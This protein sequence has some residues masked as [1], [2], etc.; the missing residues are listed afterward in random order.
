MPSARVRGGCWTLTCRRVQVWCNGEKKLMLRDRTFSRRKAMVDETGKHGACAGHGSTPP[1]TSGSVQQSL[2]ATFLKRGLSR[3]GALMNGAQTLKEYI[4]SQPVQQPPSAFYRGRRS[5]GEHV[6]DPFEVWSAGESFLRLQR[7]EHDAEARRA[8]ARSR[9]LS[10]IA[11]AS[12][13]NKPPLMIRIEK[14]QSQ[15]NSPRHGA[16]SSL[17]RE[18]AIVPPITVHLPLKLRMSYGTLKDLLK[19]TSVG[20]FR[21]GRDNP[22]T[23]DLDQSK[24]D[25]HRVF[26]RW[27]RCKKR[28]E[29]RQ[30][31]LQKAG[32][33]WKH[34]RLQAA[35]ALWTS[36]KKAQ[37]V[38]NEGLCRVNKCL[39]NTDDSPEQVEHLQLNRHTLE[40]S[41]AYADS[42]S[43]RSE[44]KHTL[45][46]LVQIGVLENETTVN[47][48]H[49]G[50]CWNDGN[51]KI[52][53]QCD[54]QGRPSAT[55]GKRGST[56]EVSGALPSSMSRESS[57]FLDVLSSAGNVEP[58]PD[59]IQRADAGVGGETEE[60]QTTS[61]RTWQRAS[62]YELAARALVSG[63]NSRDA[64]RTTTTRAPVL[65]FPF[66]SPAP[67]C[68]DDSDSL[69]PTTPPP[70]PV[71]S[72][73]SFGK[74]AEKAATLTAEVRQ[75]AGCQQWHGARPER[76][77][78]YSQGIGKT[79]KEQIKAGED[80]HSLAASDA[81]RQL[82]VPMT[83]SDS[84]STISSTSSLPSTS[85]SGVVS[86]EQELVR[87]LLRCRIRKGLAH[88]AEGSAAELSTTDTERQLARHEETVPPATVSQ[89][90]AHPGRNSGNGECHSHVCDEQGRESPR[91]LRPNRSRAKSDLEL[92][93]RR[94][95]DRGPKLDWKVAAGF[96]GQLARNERSFRLQCSEG[97]QSRT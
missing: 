47:L 42:T 20:S 44:M 63:A 55:P 76:R 51:T 93:L 10:R 33:R 17:S 23:D 21:P 22:V 7:A 43:V 89:H 40:G 1:E 73:T 64:G 79:D 16:L 38:P 46:K 69:T 92:A 14:N 11:A 82:T 19:S 75:R 52:H 49:D 12:A 70:P 50:H 53:A 74:K 59:E 58:Q 65:R 29:R 15:D 94:D 81:S 67:S 71:E 37:L 77:S 39:L 57:T 80:F 87:C 18:T 13:V 97:H 84:T 48:G 28:G 30:S 4:E 5:G 32:R 34:R 41:K 86:A 61:C 56:Q 90:G 9:A 72:V 95:C 78:V 54:H 25:L 83:A 68:S 66:S 85:S 8:L 26:M 88:A 27:G 2:N 91:V 35:F 96:Y 36:K 6:P 31:L 24:R 45:K 3:A 62:L 60:E